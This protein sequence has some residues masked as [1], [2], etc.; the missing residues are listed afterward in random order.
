[1]LKR[2]VMIAHRPDPCAE[3]PSLPRFGAGA[4]D[5]DQVRLRLMARG[6]RRGSERQAHRL[7]RARSNG[8]PG[9]SPLRTFP[10]R[11]VWLAE[12]VAVG[13]W[14]RRAQR[15]VRYHPDADAPRRAKTQRRLVRPVVCQILSGAALPSASGSVRPLPNSV[16]QDATRQRGGQLFTRAIAVSDS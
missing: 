11:Q 1:V 9:R 15:R 12:E 4:L 8:A 10:S 7:S 5:P 16:H 3:A 14:R 6:I 13:D 2:E